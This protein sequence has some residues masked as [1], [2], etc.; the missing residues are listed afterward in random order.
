VAR[1]SWTY[2]VPL[3][4]SGSAGLEEYMVEDRSG[5]PVGKVVTLLEH[6]GE[7]YVLVERGRPPVRN[8]RRAVL[9]SDVEAV[10]HEALAV[11]IDLTGEELSQVLQVDPEKQV[12]G[13][14]A[15][16]VRALPPRPAAT[17][18]DVP[19]PVDRAAPY[20]ATLALG[21]IGLIVLLGL[22]L[23]ASTTDFDWEYVLFVIPA[24]LFVGALMTGYNLTR[25]PYEGTKT[26]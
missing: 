9:W 13:G 22:F 7:H 8:D 12:E 21:A 19:G 3:A 26:K 25:R 20:A 6:G 23:F 18:A 4:G 15:E 10:D 5:E 17:S 11:R 14:P 24:A 1:A 16:A 2:E